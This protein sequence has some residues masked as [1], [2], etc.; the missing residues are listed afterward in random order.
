MD[1]PLVP[2]LLQYIHW[3]WLQVVFKVESHPLELQRVHFPPAFAPKQ[4]WQEDHEH[5][6]CQLLL[7]KGADSTIVTVYGWTPLELAH[8]GGHTDIV[9]I[10][11][12]GGA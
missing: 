5:L 12:S 4:P 2:H 11:Q 7:I 6:P 3:I 10:L 9:Q 1:A 8:N